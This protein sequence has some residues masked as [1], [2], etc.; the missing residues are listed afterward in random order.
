MTKKCEKF[1]HFLVILGTFFTGKCCK[2]CDPI[3]L[4]QIVTQEK[5]AKKT[6][7]ILTNLGVGCAHLFLSH[8][9]S[10]HVW[11]NSMRGVLPLVFYLGHISASFRNTR[12]VCADNA[13]TRQR[14]RAHASPHVV[15]ITHYRITDVLMRRNRSVEC[16]R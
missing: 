5:N 8:N 4:P 11:V 9:R 2:S 14:G 6:T 15:S 12:H 7:R 3:D 16:R 10:R 1:S 13:P